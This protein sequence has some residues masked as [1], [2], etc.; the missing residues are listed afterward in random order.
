LDGHH[1]PHLGRAI[2]TRLGSRPDIQPAAQLQLG[3]ACRVEGAAQAL[4][5]GEELG[6]PEA[7]PGWAVQQRQGRIHLQGEG[8]PGRAVQPEAGLHGGRG[9]GLDAWPQGH[10]RPDGGQGEAAPARTRHQATEIQVPHQADVERG[11]G[12]AGAMGGG[13]GGGDG[14]GRNRCGPGEAGGGEG[15]AEGKVEVDVHGGLP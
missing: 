5:G 14:P 3:L 6:H 13:Q 8:G 1:E 9:S 7:A 10:H 2:Q 15:E 12:E 4:E 11:L